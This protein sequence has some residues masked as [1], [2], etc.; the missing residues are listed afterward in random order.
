MSAATGLWRLTG[1]LPGALKKSHTFFQTFSLRKC[2]QLLG[3][4]TVQTICF[5]LCVKKTL[6]I[7]HIIQML[8]KR[9]APLRTV[10]LKLRQN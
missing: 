9:T 10:A 7:R 5:T 6:N 1:K 4:L 8:K 3:I 2:M